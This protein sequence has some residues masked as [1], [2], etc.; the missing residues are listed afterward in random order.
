MAIDFS[1]TIPKYN[2]F[3][4]KGQSEMCVIK[5]GGARCHLLSICVE[6]NEMKIWMHREVS[7]YL[8]LQYDALKHV[9]HC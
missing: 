3:L 4:G 6:K 2:G 9:N 7:G 5:T 8:L 1:K